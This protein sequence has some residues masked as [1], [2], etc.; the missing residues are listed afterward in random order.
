[1]ARR[2]LKKYYN[3]IFDLHLK[4]GFTADQIAQVLSDKYEEIQPTDGRAFRFILENNR[5][6]YSPA[7]VLVFDIETAPLKAWAWSMWKPYLNYE[8]IEQDWFMLCWSAKWLFDE[9]VLSDTCTP[10]EV[11]NEDDRRIS[12][13]LWNLLEEADIV[14]AHNGI[15]FDIKKVNTR[16][17]M[18]GL[19]RP[20]PFQVIDTLIHARK[21]LSFTS[22]RLDAIGEIMGLGR[23]L[24][25]SFSLW[26]RCME[27]EQEAL[28][29]MSTYCDQDVKLLEAVYLKLR[30]FINPHPN[31]GL[32]IGEDVRTCSTCG[33]DEKHLEFLDSNYV[34]YANAYTAFRCKSCGAIGRS[35]ESNTPK[36]AKK[37]MLISTP[38]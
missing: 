6:D 1:M 2:S 22:N 5:K 16:F 20:S 26:L 23:K 4:D 14:I 12:E 27:Q 17:L 11:A 19:N 24:Q 9:E 15:K 33:A 32:Y 25:T 7:K 30:P 36:A 34:T 8:N 10:E 13:S 29:E 18:H 37:N 28:D 31:M 35:R 38:K 3:E 21:H